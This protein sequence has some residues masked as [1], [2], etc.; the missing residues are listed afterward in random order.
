MQSS[1]AILELTLSSPF[2]TLP[3]GWLPEAV[4]HLNFSNAL[5]ALDFLIQANHQITSP[6]GCF[7][8]FREEAV[9]EESNEV[10]N[11]RE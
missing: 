2:E 10:G 8:R 5:N 6:R 1:S 7:K 4:D 9:I 3:V 11:A